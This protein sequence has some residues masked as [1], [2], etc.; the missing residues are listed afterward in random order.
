[1]ASFAYTPTYVGLDEATQPT[2]E[3]VVLPETEP[4]EQGVSGD[5]ADTLV[6]ADA[7]CAEIGDSGSRDSGQSD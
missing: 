6:S 2:G 3:L 4:S 5:P 7:V 1:M